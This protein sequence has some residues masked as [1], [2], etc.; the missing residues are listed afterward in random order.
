MISR[1]F[2]VRWFGVIIFPMMV[3]LMESFWLYPWFIWVGN[4]PLFAAPRPPLS[5]ASVILLLTVSQ[6]LSR[7]LINRPWRLRWVRLLI[8]TAGLAAVF[9]VVRIEY[10]GGFRLF[11]DEW[12]FQA[13]R[14]FLDSFSHP[15][16]MVGAPFL[17]LFLWWRG[18]AWGRSY[19]DSKDIYRSFVAG[20]VFMVLSVIMWGISLPGMPVSS[21]MLYAAGFFFFG[22]MALALGN[23]H[24]LQERMRKAGENALLFSRRWLSL[25][26]GL[27]S[28][29]VLIAMAATGVIS[30]EFVTLLQRLMDLAFEG[31]VWLIV[32]ISIP[33]GLIGQVVYWIVMF[34]INLILGKE[35]PALPSAN[36]TGL[37]EQTEELPGRFLSPEIIMVIKWSLFGIILAGVLFLM[38]WA[39]F[40]YRSRESDSGIE[41]FHESLWSWT[42]LKTDLRLFLGSLLRRGSERTAQERLHNHD[43]N[44]HEDI[45]DVREIYRRLLREAS[46]VGVTRH[47]WETPYEYVRRLQAA[48]PEGSAPLVELTELY[49]GVRYGAL[50]AEEAVLRH[51]NALWRLLRQLMTSPKS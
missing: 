40:R 32:I 8:V 11:G 16:T 37:G 3:L 27:I 45:M 6:S 31:L 2:K 47:H 21:I 22:L 46:E 43:E 36:V 24:V 41:E 9:T 25:L 26:S 14:I 12:F 20:I 50:Q 39:V 42:G 17:G 10:G 34:F 13:G 5:L 48:V 30:S 33:F 29:I 19:L 44:D 49:I 18:I 7:F 1:L 51:A 4:L 15:H 35:I 23:F 28:G 38:A